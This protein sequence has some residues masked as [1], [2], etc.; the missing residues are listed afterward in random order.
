MSDR[1]LAE[2]LDRALAGE[3][4][5]AEAR[6]LA[7]LLL[8]AAEPARFKV[9]DRDVEQALAAVRPARVRRRLRAAPA[10]AGIAA[11][12]AAALAL[13]LVDT[14][15]TDLQARAARAVDHTFFVV[16]QVRAAH[17]AFPAGQVSGYVDGA[18]GRAH[19]RVSG[20]H[21]LAAELVIDRD[22]TVERWLRAT[23]TLTLSPS[24]REL[25]ATCTEVLD[26]FDLYLRMI[27]RGDVT[28]RRVGDT[29]R[30]SIRRGSVEATAVIDARSYLPRSIE[31]RQNGRAFSRTRFLAVE[32]QPTEVGA[33]AWTMS[34]HRGAR[35]VQLTAHGE[36]V[37]V[38]SERPVRPTPA[39][40]WLGPRYCGARARAFHVTLSDG[41][42]TRVD[43]G[44]LAV[45]NYGA[46]VPPAVLRS[47][48]LPTKVFVGSG[49]RIVHVWIGDAGTEVAEASFGNRNVAVVS[50][51]GD[52]AD[53]VRAIQQIRRRG[54][55]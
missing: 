55:P 30:L 42:A 25:G 35:V 51:A 1:S 9:D 26:P 8:A 41:A 15:G 39:T 14:P 31:W 24:C 22:G 27:E 48:S 6:E 17:G 23:N 36:R 40:W 43:Y 34:T 33:D 37:R 47:R 20:A 12:A 10:F 16:Q 4:A 18:A 38:L 32:R 53:V 46:I 54:S 44:P 21:G 45:W 13:L 5:G 28:S 29:Y 52:R 49:G 7:G 3:A 19:L 2:Q 50:A 11:I